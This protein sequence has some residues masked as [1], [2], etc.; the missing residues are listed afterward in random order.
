MTDLLWRLVLA[1]FWQESGPSVAASLV[2]LAVLLV[3]KS[4]LW[5][6]AGWE[7]SGVWNFAMATGAR[8]AGSTVPP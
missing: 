6:L 1:V 5:V 2:V 3:D 8:F 4:G 7:G